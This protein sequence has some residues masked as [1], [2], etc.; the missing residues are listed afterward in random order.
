M[1][2]LKEILYSWQSALQDIIEFMKISLINTEIGIE[3][4]KCIC[5]EM[6]S[7]ID[8]VFALKNENLTYQALSC[9]H[10][11]ISINFKLQLLQQT[12]LIDTLLS[13]KSLKE[14]YFIEI[15]KIFKEAF[16][17]S[18]KA[19][20]LEQ[21]NIDIQNLQKNFD[22]TEITNIDKILL[23]YQQIISKINTFP[24]IREISS[25]SFI[26]WKNYY[27]CYMKIYKNLSP[28]EYND[29]SEL[30]VQIFIELQKILLEKSQFQKLNENRI[31]DLLM[32]NISEDEYQDNLSN[33]SY[34]LLMDDLI[35]CIYQGLYHFKKD[36][37]MQ[38]FFKNICDKI[39]IDQN[40]N[41]EKN[42]QKIKEEHILQIEA[43]FFFL[44][45]CY[46]IS[47]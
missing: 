19:E 30:I 8:N 46:I 20:M 33:S 23:S 4:L 10:T 29:S 39:I 7:N 45:I 21:E 47:I 16:A 13:L 37:G 18:D 6:Q 9:L 15:C 22:Q 36:Q 38:L 11:W 26:S 44:R 17:N 34:R 5:E 27:E 3:I 24:F 1:K 43:A 12:Q 14:S 31:A 2:V 35:Q 32:N 40:Q 28:D 25:D 42:Q 41:S